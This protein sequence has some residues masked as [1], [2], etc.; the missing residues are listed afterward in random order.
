MDDRVLHHDI[1]QLFMMAC[2]CTSAVIGYINRKKFKNTKHFFLYPLSSF[3]EM[4][5]YF[6]AIYSNLDNK[7]REIIIY[8][9][10]NIYILIEFIIIY[11]FFLTVLKSEIIKTILYAIAILYLAL[12][13]YFWCIKNHFFYHPINLFNWQAFA[14]L[15]PTISYFLELFRHPLSINLSK[16]HNFWIALGVMFYFGCTFPL[17]LMMTFDVNTDYILRSYVYFINY[18]CYSIFFLIIAKAYLCPKELES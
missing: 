2:S 7:T 11:H 14:I 13:C 6:G 12:T 5:L 8:S 18:T 3:I 15:I 4:S 9:S 10:Y 17:F 1:A 16:S